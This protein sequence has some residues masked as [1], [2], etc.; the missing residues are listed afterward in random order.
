MHLCVWGVF[1]FNES[2]QSV[3]LL[4]PVQ[5]GKHLGS[6]IDCT[7]SSP[8]Q[9]GAWVTSAPIP[10][11]TIHMM[12]L[13]ETRAGWGARVSWWVSEPPIV[14]M[15]ISSA[16]SAPSSPLE[17][18]SSPFHTST[19]GRIVWLGTT[20]NYGDTGVDLARPSFLIG[21][22]PLPGRQHVIEGVPA[23]ACSVMGKEDRRIF[24]R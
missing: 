1:Y 11:V 21:Y 6:T 2:T 19:S 4:I 14:S 15:C 23:D 16:Y 7:T 22:P 13:M 12:R 8:A 24:M 18:S 5:S 10:C 9:R 3:S 20:G 17:H